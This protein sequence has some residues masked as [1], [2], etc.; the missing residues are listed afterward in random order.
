MSDSTFEEVRK[1][2]ALA[3]DLMPRDVPDVY[4][5]TCA[6]EKQLR[7]Y[8][9]AQET[10]R[11]QEHFDDGYSLDGFFGDLLFSIPFESY[12]TEAESHGRVVALRCEGKNAVLIY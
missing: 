11:T 6:V 5:M 9:M 12:A 2:V 4:V 3:R 1:A 10:S 8:F 7:E